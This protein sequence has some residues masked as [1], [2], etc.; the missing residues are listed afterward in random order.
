MMTNTT[1][2]TSARC[3]K[4]ETKMIKAAEHI[5]ANDGDGAINDT[6]MAQDHRVAEPLS[7]DGESK[8][9]STAGED[10]PTSSYFTE[11]KR[12]FKD[13]SDDVKPSDENEPL[14]KFPLKKARTAYFIF[15]DE[16][17]EELKQLVSAWSVLLLL[18][19]FGMYQK[20]IIRI[21]IMTPFSDLFGLLI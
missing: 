17:R 14:P 20:F 11:K 21:L 10:T 19:F 15:A 5:A 6:I 3:R 8:D 2:K 16:K 13:N 4:E 18:N 7:G 9:E 1:D 12:P